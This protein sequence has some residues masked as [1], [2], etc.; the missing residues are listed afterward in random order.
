MELNKGYDQKKALE[1]IQAVAQD[2]FLGTDDDFEWRDFLSGWSSDT[3]WVRVG[4]SY[5]LKLV[6]S[7]GGGEGEG[8]LVERVIKVSTHRDV[9]GYVQING[10][11]MSYDGTTWDDPSEFEIVYPK[12][13]VV[14]QYFKE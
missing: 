1:I 2:D 4:D 10:Y 9:L 8:E 3:A 11:Y 12:E 6:H 13:V 5:C 7:V 14:V